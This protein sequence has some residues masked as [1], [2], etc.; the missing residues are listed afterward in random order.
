MES[1]RCWWLTVCRWVC[2]WSTTITTLYQLPLQQLQQPATILCG[3]SIWFTSTS[4]IVRLYDKCQHL[5]WM[6]MY[7]IS[8]CVPVVKPRTASVAWLSSIYKQL[9]SSLWLSVCINRTLYSMGYYCWIVKSTFALQ[10]LVPL[11]SLPWTVVCENFSLGC[12][13]C[14][15][16]CSLYARTACMTL[17]AIL[18]SRSI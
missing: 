3:W 18:V 14:S 9:V 17:F 7:M 13:S 6:Y 15:D 4:V 10:L 8:G 5:L 12:R 11:D 1:V 2:V 16:Y